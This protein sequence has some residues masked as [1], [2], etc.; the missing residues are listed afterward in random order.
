MYALHT[1]IDGSTVISIIVQY[2]TSTTGSSFSS[3]QAVTGASS[4]S[5]AETSTYFPKAIPDPILPS[6]TLVV[7]QTTSIVIFQTSSID[8]GTALIVSTRDTLSPTPN[9]TPKPASSPYLRPSANIGIGVT[10][11]VAF[12]LACVAFLLSTRQKRKRLRYLKHDTGDVDSNDVSKAA[13]PRPLGKAWV[14]TNLRNLVSRLIHRYKHT[15]EP[16]PRELQVDLADEG[17]EEGA[18]GHGE[19]MNEDA[20][21]LIGQEQEG[22]HELHDTRVSSYSGELV[23]SLGVWR[24]ELAGRQSSE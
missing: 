3:I 23:G 11:P 14:G 4:D 13:H 10:L 9:I 5:T 21:A 19:W 18:T 16:I 2:I 7:T 17:E 1:T 24:H 22:A 15:R 20:S 6:N 12:V 8:P